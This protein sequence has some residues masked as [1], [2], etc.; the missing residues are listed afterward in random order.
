[1]LLP[2][3]QE[4][5]V[6]NTSKCNLRCEYCYVYR[7]YEDIPR[8]EMQKETMDALIHFAMH[9]LM[10]NGRIWFFGGEPLASFETM[11][12]ITEKARAENLAIQ[13]GLTSNCTLLDEEK[14]MWMRKYNYQILCSLDGSQVL[15]NKHRKY[16]DGR[17]SFEDAWRGIQLVRKYLNP[18][19]QL[20]W[21]MHIDTVE[22]TTEAMKNLIEQGLTNLAI[23]PV[24]EVKWDDD[25]LKTL[26]NELVKMSDLL[27]KCYEKNIPVFS[28]FVRDVVTAVT[29]TSRV[30]W[31]DRCGLGQGGVGVTPKGEI[32]PC[33]RY[34]SSG[35][36][37]IGTV[38]E[39][40][41]PKRL[42]WIENWSMIP[43]YSENPELCLNC[44]FKNACMGG[45][46]AMN[47]DLFEDPHIIPESMCKIKQL[48]VEVFK[49]LVLK[50]QNN[51]IFKQLYGV[52]LQRPCM[53]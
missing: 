19:P 3:L 49:P 4:L 51:P 11:K 44:N 12:Y 38:F 52:G 29:N 40:F 21:T 37:V 9:H 23:D 24:Y 39:G 35:Q 45:C 25:A 18:V 34:V 15:H 1:M 27:D 16:A 43:P 32:T 5:T 47:Y 46:L 8:Q 48:S 10:Y 50:H 33:H 42:E 28:M 31:T 2:P 6:W 36:P 7:L 41:S 26:R 17:G 14:V 20:R 13:F 53:E 22:G 30:N